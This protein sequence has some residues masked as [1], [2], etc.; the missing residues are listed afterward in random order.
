[1]LCA[2]ALARSRQ[3]LALRFLGVGEGADDLRPFVAGEFAAALL[4]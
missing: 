2:I 1:V 4:G 3:P